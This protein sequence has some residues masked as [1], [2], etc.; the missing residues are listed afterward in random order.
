MPFW[1]KFLFFLLKNYACKIYKL[2]SLREESVFDKNQA[3]QAGC[4]TRTLYITL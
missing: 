1:T 2:M 4:D 3:D